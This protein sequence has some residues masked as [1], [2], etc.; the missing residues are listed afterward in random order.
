MSVHYHVHG[1]AVDARRLQRSQ[2]PGVQ[3]IQGRRLRTLAIVADTGVYDD[4]E[5][6]DLNDPALHRDAPLIG[7]GIEEVR[8]QQV[9]MVPPARRGGSGEKLGTQLELKFHD[10][11]HA[12]ATQPD[13]SHHMGLVRR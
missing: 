7:V 11:R 8:D 6:V 3:V 1:V 2:E 4:G 9:G 10:A 5:A 13:A 12:R